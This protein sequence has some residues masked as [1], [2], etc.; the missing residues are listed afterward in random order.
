MSKQITYP[1]TDLPKVTKDF[2]SNRN[3][4]LS[5]F[6]QFVK[7]YLG[8]NINRPIDANANT[9]IILAVNQSVNKKTFSELLKFT[10]IDIFKKN[11]NG[12]NA[13]DYAV[14][15]VKFNLLNLLER[16]KDLS[17]YKLNLNNTPNKLTIKE[18][19]HSKKAT[20]IANVINDNTYNPNDNNSVKEVDFLKFVQKFLK[21][22]SLTFE[23]IK[24]FVDNNLGGNINKPFGN[25]NNTLLIEAIKQEIN[26]DTLSNIL[27]FPNID[28]YQCNS[29]NLNAIDLASRKLRPAV[30]QVF[31]LVDDISDYVLKGLNNKAGYQVKDLFFI[32]KLSNNVSIVKKP[33]A[34]E[35]SKK[36]VKAHNAEQTTVEKSNILS[37]YIPVNASAADTKLINLSNELSQK[38]LLTEE[39]IS[40]FV[41]KHLDGD[42]NKPIDSNKNTL[43]IHWVNNATHL[44]N[45]NVLINYKDINFKQ[46]N[47]LKLNAIDYVISKFKASIYKLLNSVENITEYVIK[48]PGDLHGFQAKDIFEIS[49][50]NVIIKYSFIDAIFSLNRNSNSD[51]SLE[52]QPIPFSNSNSNN[53]AS[54]SILTHRKHFNKMSI[55]DEAMNLFKIKNLSSNEM[56]NKIQEFVDNYLEGDINRPFDNTN[57]TLIALGIAN[58]MNI[59]TLEVLLNFENIDIFKTNIHGLNAVDTAVTKR[60]YHYVKKINSYKPIADYI[61]HSK[62][63]KNGMKVK[64]LVD[65]KS[66]TYFNKKNIADEAMNLFKI[67]NLS[68]NEMR[69]KIQE[70]VDTYLEGDINKPFGNTNHTL[71]ALGMANRMNIMTLEALLNFE[72]IDIF[73]T[74]INGL[75]AIDI[76]IGKMKYHYVKKINSYKPID[77]YIVHSKGTKNGMKVKD[78]LNSVNNIELNKNSKVSPAESLNS[79]DSLDLNN[80]FSANNSVQIESLNPV[81]QKKAKM[82]DYVEINNAS[83][84]ELHAFSI[85]DKIAEEPIAQE[86]IAQERE[87]LGNGEESAEL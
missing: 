25:K 60:K 44:K 22:R 48:A 21:M 82:E 73:K 84:N 61:V 52:N 76:A 46:D 2:L 10:H 69:N 85:L 54:N 18:F 42:I 33:F 3:I 32:T 26:T 50:N 39:D 37:N 75:N 11:I 30:F 56:R 28:I 57:H 29:N 16:F 6:E 87:A 51:E 7:T 65:L 47:S 1:S 23:Q 68:S 53:N 36:N 4:H 12:K 71:I 58:S 79:E 20:N 43:L 59:M 40:D 77:D 13:I 67:K 17:E 64:D 70:F 81:P 14:T 62:G 8:G 78:I 41:N 27:K 83:H 9:L 38:T 24:D 86:N 66:N 31:Y 72:N 35:L 80:N 15:R 74:N 5:E 19:L 45:L 55:A 63:T 49:D 34:R